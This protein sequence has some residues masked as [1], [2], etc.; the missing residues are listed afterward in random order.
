[1]LKAIE[2][3][4]LEDWEKAVLYAFLTNV[5]LP[6]WATGH[7]Q[8]RAFAAVTGWPEQRC[9][10]ALAEAHRKGTAGRAA[11]WRFVPCMSPR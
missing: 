1:M 4:F 9:L 11:R 7:D 5:G 8:W 10:S 2:P 6:S 3:E